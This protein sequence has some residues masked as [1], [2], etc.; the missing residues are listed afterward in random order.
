MLLVALAASTGQQVILALA[1]RKWQA[2]AGIALGSLGEAA[3]GPLVRG[4]VV[5]AASQPPR[6]LQQAASGMPLHLAPARA[7]PLTAH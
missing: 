7:P 6:R 2:F 1:A 5:G 3:G 4:A